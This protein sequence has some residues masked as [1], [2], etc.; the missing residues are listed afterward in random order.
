MSRYNIKY[1]PLPSGD[2][3]SPASSWHIAIRS[4][5]IWLYLALGAAGIMNIFLVL[6]WWHGPPLTPLDNYQILKDNFRIVS[7]TTPNSTAIVTTLY[8]ELYTLPILTL[9]YSLSAHYDNANS[10]EYPALP[11]PRRLLMYIPHRISP[12][13]LC[14]ARSVGWEPHPVEFIAPPHNGAGVGPRF[15]DQY[16]K[17]ALW[18][19]DQIGIEKVVYLDGD[20]LVR[21][22]FDELFAMPFDFAAVPDIYGDERGF[23]LSFNA[24]VL[25]LRPSTAVFENLFAR[26]EEAV[27]PPIMAE[28]AY[29]NL[30]FGAEVVRLPYI[31]NANLA[32]KIRSR[33]LWDFMNQSD[34]LRIVHY[35]TPKPF[36]A[37][38]TENGG[39]REGL[40]QAQE[41]VRQHI[42]EAKKVNGGLYGEEIGWWEDAWRDMERDRHEEMER[43]MREIEGESAR[44]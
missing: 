28:Q 43:C 18:K 27:Y 44:F 4:R 21:R 34:A 24:G 30:Y 29:L 1:L 11:P 2:W 32:G 19:L 3:P 8:N 35:T 22:R 26:M 7:S 13:T 12:L 17:L 37:M 20:T 9:G 25:A 42:V 38:G 41:T 23:A 15:G 6:K 16:T 31:Y 33:K 10:S 40:R 39:T 14:L 36:P 5:H